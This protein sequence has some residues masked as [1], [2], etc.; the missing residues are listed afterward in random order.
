MPEN[1]GTDPAGQRALVL[2]LAALPLAGC[3]HVYEAPAAPGPSEWPTYGG[4]P[5]R[6]GF[7]AAEKQLDV[8]A[9]EALAPRWQVDI[10][11][12]GQPPS[13]TPSIAGGRV[14][15]GSSVPDG[16]NFFALDARSG[17]RLWS[18][19]VGHSD[20]SAA[21]IGIGATPAVS[22]SIVVAGGG[23]QAYYG[24]RADTGEVLWRHAMDD[25]PSGFAW[26]SPLVASGRAYVGM[27]SEFDNPSVRGEVRALD[28]ATGTVLARQAFVPEGMGGAGVWNSPALSPDGRTLL[29]V[30]GEDFGGYDG[31]YNRAFLALDPVTL[32]IRQSDKQGVP[33]EDQ[34]WGTTP[35]VF[36][37][38]SSRVL[39]GAV[40]K[41]GVFYAY[42]LDGIE[43]GPVWQR[44]T[45][46]AAGFMPAYNP[47]LGGGGTLFIG[48]GNGQVYAVDPASGADRWGP[49]TLETM[50]GNMALAN[51]LLFAP[52]ATGKVFVVE[53]ATGRV[54]RVLTPANAGPS[55]SGVAV[56]GGMVY[57]LSGSTLNAWG[58]P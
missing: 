57:W 32:A 24:L 9:V 38:L 56:A 8:S 26:C 13:G 20:V 55:Y 18:V 15:V 47:I 50:H 1:R 2:V 37:D 53:S 54:L 33:D 46:V 30:S 11:M 19:S 42:A 36:H 40:H 25:G 35:V 48:G 12:G 21:G 10:G 29:V 58:V 7:N 17:Q 41:N 27:S 43:A 3:S 39:V 34:D 51:G 52:A 5:G 14:F 49:L 44:A 31:P 4:E 22:G 28:L 45:G 16:D 23:D 6:S